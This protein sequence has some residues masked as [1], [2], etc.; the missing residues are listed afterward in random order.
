MRRLVLGLLMWA[1]VAVAQLVTETTVTSEPDLI[2]LMVKTRS[3]VIIAKTLSPSLAR[4][5]TFTHNLYPNLVIY[6]DEKNTQ[7]HCAGWHRG[8]RRALTVY[9]VKSVPEVG[10]ILIDAQQAS[11]VQGGLVTGSSVPTKRL[12]GEPMVKNMAAQ[13]LGALQGKGVVAYVC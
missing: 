3:V 10:S 12:Q 13:M 11:I 8:L 4:S 9:K 5:F 6:T 1:T 7:N 2:S